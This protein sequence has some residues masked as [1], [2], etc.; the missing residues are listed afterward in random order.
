MKAGKYSIREIFVN[1]YID[2]III[3]EI[4]R[5]YVW[6]EEQTIGLLEN[7]LEDYNGYTIGKVP[8]Q[9]D[10]TEIK[11]LF[12]QYYKKQKYSSNIGFLYAYNDPEYIG[13]YFL[14][15]GQQRITTIYLI[16]LALCIK[17][18]KTVFEKYYFTNGILK[19]DYKVRDTAHEFMNQFVKYILSGGSHII[20]KIN[21]QHWYF[22]SNNL[23]PTVQSI[24]SNYYH[25]SG[26]LE[27][28]NL[29]NDDFLNYV[30]HFIEFWYFDTNLSD[31]GEELYIY[32][33]AR[34]EQIQ[35]NENLKA[36]LLGKLGIDDIKAVEKRT[37]FKESKDV[38]GLKNYWGKQWENWQ[39]FF[40]KR[41]GKNENADIGFNEFIDCIAGLELYKKKLE[42][43]EVSNLKKTDILGL[44]SIE[45]Y[46]N[47]LTYLE[48]ERESFSAEYNSCEWVNNYFNLI[49]SYINK[50][51]KRSTN[52]FADYKDTNKNED[53]NHM[54]LLWSF[55]NYYEFNC[56]KLKRNEFFRVLRFFYV[57]YHNYNRSV[58]TLKKTIEL[59]SNRG[60]FDTNDNELGVIDNNQEEETDTKLRTQEEKVKYTFLGEMFKDPQKIMEYEA[61]IWKIEDHKYNLDGSY[62]K[63]KNISHLVDFEAKPS[64]EDLQNICDRFYLL[65]SFTDGFEEKMLVTLLL[66]Y[67]EFWCR[68]TPWYYFNF[69]F[70]NW[71]RIIRGA[72]GDG[73]AFKEFFAE[74]LAYNIPRTLSELLKQK[75]NA[76]LL[77]NA[78]N[79][80]TI[81][82]FRE[83]LI[84]YSILLLDIWWDGYHICYENQ[85]PEM[86]FFDKELIMFNCE[87]Y[88]GS[89]W[90][91]WDEVQTQFN[92]R[93]IMLDILHEKIHVLTQNTNL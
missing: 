13:K 8:V 83:Q 63:N 84:I 10:D 56:E 1:N 70:N 68:V 90:Y 28:N 21:Q 79:L 81:S 24:L 9:T 12:E 2:Q 15:D 36:D 35:S 14:I 22:S 85:E 52:W 66:H 49:W 92:E 26:F 32:M 38:N 77:K 60:I 67:G 59:I 88:K 45:C 44:T 69:E 89:H 29:Y 39:D 6:G 25:I 65:M 55:L 74:F 62:L 87:R 23:D 73:K 61:I 3:P 72:D 33:N 64:L 27:K 41:K 20:E 80:N 17:I 51:I 30:Q 18:D 78:T 46:I 82:D 54:V 40:W 16:L 58:S 93:T 47:A 37:D 43:A 53:R 7:I 48:N 71:R 57:R 75:N 91:F 86:R 50:S 5:D 11:A 42:L 31:Q 19:V 34:G 76:L 4:Q